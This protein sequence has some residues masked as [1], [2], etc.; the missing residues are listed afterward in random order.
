MWVDAVCIAQENV[1]ER[2][3]QVGLMSLIYKQAKRVAV[4]LGPETANSKTAIS[5]L[6]QID[7]GSI[8]IKQCDQLSY[9]RNWEAVSDFF[10]IQY[11]K[12]LWI[13]Q[14]I[15]LASRVI[16]HCGQD[17][18]QGETLLRIRETLWVNGTFRVW[19]FSLLHN[20]NKTTPVALLLHQ[21]DSPLS[22]RVSAPL[23]DLII[24]FQEAQCKDTRDNIFGLLSL[25]RP[26]CKAS[27]PADYTKTAL[28]IYISVLEHFRR[29]HNSIADTFPERAVFDLNILSTCGALNKDQ[30]WHCP[31][32][33]HP[34]MNIGYGAESERAHVMIIGTII[35]TLPL[36]SLISSI[37]PWRDHSTKRDL[38]SWYV[39]SAWNYFRYPP[40]TY[41]APASL[42]K[43]RRKAGPAKTDLN[44]AVL[45]GGVKRNIFGRDQEIFKSWHDLVQDAQGI[46]SYTRLL[47]QTM[48]R[49]P[50]RYLP[51]SQLSI[52]LD[53]NGMM[54]FAPNHIKVGDSIWEDG[55]KN[56][57]LI[58]RQTSSGCERIAEARKK[59]YEP[60]H[61]L[62]PFQ[63]DDYL[64][65]CHLT[66]AS[67][68]SDGEY[69][70][71]PSPI[72]Y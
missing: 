47:R 50:E 19:N 40:A 70:P 37:G 16:L 61:D 26:C 55:T 32:L 52:F 2:N 12:R 35:C 71:S 39:K 33:V 38:F 31:H 63:T 17:L 1:F 7:D 68:P 29:E 54:G 44:P 46:S 5:W 65:H 22:P 13:I 64:L 42:V 58:L 59:L 15:V 51:E 9:K 69:P 8:P 3:H 18:L 30:I 48:S 20:F 49:H 72:K 34:H 36:Q 11:W 25:S 23:M 10:E 56:T 27:T 60:A 41:N 57:L 45:K 66:F 43:F 28:E 6:K 4:W 24:Q 62:T 21:S 53:S 67:L 14:E